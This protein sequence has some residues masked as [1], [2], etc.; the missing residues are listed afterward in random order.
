ML[1]NVSFIGSRTT[2]VNTATVS[3]ATLALPLNLP[4]TPPLLL[5]SL[6]AATVSMTTSERV[7]FV[8]VRVTAQTKTVAVSCPVGWGIGSTSTVPTGQPRCLSSTTM[9]TLEC[10][11]TFM[12]PSAGAE[13]W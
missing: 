3:L 8:L 10:C 5:T 13:Q 12:Q 9:C 4:L 7:S 6:R 11:L 2:C 1:L